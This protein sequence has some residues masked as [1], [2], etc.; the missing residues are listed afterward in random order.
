ML[1][2]TLREKKYFDE[3]I[4]FDQGVIDKDLASLHEL[5][6]PAGKAG[7]TNRLI[8]Q[9]TQILIQRYGRGDALVDLRSS[10]EQILNLMEINQNLLASIELDKN[11]RDMYTNLDL[12]TLYNAFVCL[13]CMKA[14]R[15]PQHD[16]HEALNL[17]AHP[18]EDALLDQIAVALGSEGRSI[19]ADSKYPKIYSSLLDIISADEAARPALLKKYVT[20]WYKKM[21]PI[22]WYDAHNAAEGAY[23]GYWCF[24]AALVAMLWAIDDSQLQDHPNYPSDLVRHYRQS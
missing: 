19:A 21:K 14:L 11:V 10:I 18:G 16:I 17:I 12:G 24:E 15:L 1:R 3:G 13:A 9:A 7:R 20:A 5:P 6:K 2:D 4:A 22:Y 23:F 8:R